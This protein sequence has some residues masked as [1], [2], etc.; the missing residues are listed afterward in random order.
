MCVSACIAIAYYVA[1]L[2][3]WI[4]CGGIYPSA[5]SKCANG[6]HQCSLGFRVQGL[7]FQY[8]YFISWF[9]F[10]L[11]LMVKCLFGK[12]EPLYMMW[13]SR[14]ALFLTSMQHLIKKQTHLNSRDTTQQQS[15]QLYSNRSILVMPQRKNWW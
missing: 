2:Y 13:F 5:Y 15:Y 14:L 10:H 6:C 7:E 9:S 12:V 11:M 8:F 3:T 1:P 4:S